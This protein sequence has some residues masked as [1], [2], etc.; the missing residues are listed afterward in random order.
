MVWL[1]RW[2]RWKWRERSC[3]WLGRLQGSET[4]CVPVVESRECS[5]VVVRMPSWSEVNGI[6][7]LVG[8]VMGLVVERHQGWLVG[9]DW[10]TVGCRLVR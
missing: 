2:G 9:G 7:R 4:G 5:L 1:G 10:G 8:I 6:G 3:C